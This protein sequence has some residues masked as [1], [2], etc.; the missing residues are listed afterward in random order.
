MVNRSQDALFQLIHSLKKGEKRHFKLYVKRNSSK[1]DLKI[2]QLFDAID[3]MAEYNETL[4]LTKTPDIAKP[5][6]SN[7]KAYLY[8]QILAALRLLKSS[9]SL[10]LQLNEQIDY[11]HILYKKGLF[12]QSLA[13][14][15]RAKQLATNNHKFNFLVPAIALE[16]RI[17]SLHIT[18]SSEKR[19][20]ELSDEAMIIS[21][22]I[23]ITT[24]LS[25]LSL[26]LY[27]WFIKFGHSLKQ[28]EEEELIAFMQNNFPKDAWEKSG[29]YER[30]YMY[31]SLTWYHFI[32]QNFVLYYK[33]AQ[34]WVDL[35]Q[36]NIISQ[37]VETG[38]YIK[39]LHYL[40]NAHFVL[41]Q[42][43][44]SAKTLQQFEE[45]AGTERV[46]SNESF[47][48]QAFLYI[49]QGKI[50]HFFM[51]GEFEKG[52]EL[53]PEI[54]RNLQIYAPLIDRHRILVLNYKIATLLF[55][56]GNYSDAI[57]YLQRI[58]NDG[59]DLRQDLQCYARLLHL[60]AHVELGNKDLVEHLS[61]SVYRFMIQHKALTQ[62]EQEL[63]LFLQHK[64]QLTGLNFKSALQELLD[65]IRMYEKNRFETRAFAYFD[66]ISWLQA[67]IKGSTMSEVIREKNSK[68]SHP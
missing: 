56:T 32:R 23:R 24:L 1:G 7:L 64:V 52:L 37:R 63:V 27:A 6:L 13:V 60:F 43:N 25:N 49:I 33:Y 39:G 8:K 68:K 10:D 40:I 29:F 14:L 54:E 66:V 65:K 28:K 19:A 3:Q 67:R 44:R 55:G 15:Q 45:F 11:A 30:L 51:T 38:Y 62:V 18:R 50:N 5:Q 16:K 31:Q 58:I 34:K 57:N 48:S 17:E 61:K 41:N 12:L 4:L 59:S 42:V 9:D 47:S 46:Q 26:Q 22:Q 20:K 21:E 53:I 2:I 36:E 35:F